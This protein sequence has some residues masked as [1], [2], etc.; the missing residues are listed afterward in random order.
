MIPENNRL[1]RCGWLLL[2]ALSVLW[3]VAFALVDVV[4]KDLPPLSIVMASS[5]VASVIMLPVMKT[6]GATFPRG[7]TVWQPFV[8]MALLNSVVPQSLMAGGQLLISGS[9]GAVITASTPLFSVLVMAAANEERLEPLRLGGVVLGAA[10]VAFLQEPASDGPANHAIG[11]LMFL[12][13]A[14]SYALAGLWGRR[15]LADVPPVTSATCQL[16]ATVAIMLPL[17]AV[18]DRPWLLPVPS[19]ATIWALLALGALSTALAY[20]IFFEVLARAGATNVM[21]V[22]LLVPVTALVIGYTF[23]GDVLSPRHLAGAALIGV[24]LLLVDG[25]MRRRTRGGS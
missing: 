9:L 6:M 3:G 13:S 25:R 22:T 10:G 19:A 4:L 15:R 5:L 17:V 16:L 20:V 18:F 2:L 21:L 24:A 7:S 12:A 1:D 11:V 14:F 23:S 8:V